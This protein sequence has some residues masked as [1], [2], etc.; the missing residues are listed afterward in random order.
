MLKEIRSEKD[1]VTGADLFNEI[2]KTVK[3]AGKWPDI[4]EYSSADRSCTGIYHYEFDP[5]FVLYPGSNEGMYLDLAITGDYGMDSG[6]NTLY[7]GTIKTL[8]TGDEASRI[9]GA[10][11]AECLISYDNF[12]D[13]NLDAITRRGFDM[14]FSDANL[15]IS[16]LKDMETAKKRL[17]WL[18]EECPNKFKKPILRNNL[19]RKT[20]KLD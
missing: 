20:I 3:E 6:N 19:T 14:R 4:I 12:M 16:G 15:I 10:L 8:D 5:H 7:L 13:D 1:I 18:R 9:M 17:E 11:Y 2:V